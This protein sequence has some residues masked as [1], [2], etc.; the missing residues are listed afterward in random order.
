[1]MGHFPVV[2]FGLAKVSELLYYIPSEVIPDKP[3]KSLD[4]WY[5]ASHG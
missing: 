3:N 4:F 5:I 2:C 1:M